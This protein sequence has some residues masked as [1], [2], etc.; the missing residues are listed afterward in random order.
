MLSESHTV[1][2]YTLLTPGPMQ[3]LENRLMRDELDH[4]HYG[5]NFLFLLHLAYLFFFF[6]RECDRTIDC[7]ESLYLN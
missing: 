4:F 3:I 2:G 7:R 6:G 1:H 5:H